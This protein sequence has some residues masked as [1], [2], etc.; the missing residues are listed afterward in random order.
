MASM[1]P[2]QE[3][4]ERQGSAR[5]RDRHIL[6]RI[7]KVA[8]LAVIIVGHVARRDDGQK[9]FE[10]FVEGAAKPDGRE[11]EAEAPGVRDAAVAARNLRQRRCQQRAKGEMDEAVEPVAA[12]A[13]N[14]GRSWPVSA[15]AQ[16]S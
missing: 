15:R 2:A 8:L 9:P 5:L 14:A 13:Q 4:D 10:Y 7:P 3:R 16:S 11:G 12:Q 1:P 6:L